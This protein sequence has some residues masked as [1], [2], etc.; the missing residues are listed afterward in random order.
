MTYIQWPHHEKSQ[1]KTGTRLGTTC[2]LRLF[3]QPPLL[4]QIRD[5]TKARK[6]S[7]G[8][9]VVLEALGRNGDKHQCT[10]MP[11][12]LHLEK[13]YGGEHQEDIHQESGEWQIVPTP[14]QE[15]NFSKPITTNAPYL[16]TI[17]SY[18]NFEHVTFCHR[19]K[20]AQATSTENHQLQTFSQCEAL[21]A[22]VEGNSV[23]YAQLWSRLCC[24][25]TQ[26]I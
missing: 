15:Q 21:F 12:D 13:H 2:T 6:G 25:Y 1:S 19:A 26:W 23:E 8:I 4:L 22:T 9:G 24:S 18:G 17:I 16:G 11:G 10:E 7:G 14:N 20:R 5:T 3:R